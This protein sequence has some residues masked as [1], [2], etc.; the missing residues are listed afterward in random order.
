MLNIPRAGAGA[1]IGSWLA[2]VAGS[3]GDLFLPS[4]TIDTEDLINYGEI[5]SKYFAGQ[6]DDISVLYPYS[7]T[8]GTPREVFPNT[9]FVEADSR[10]VRALRRAGFD[11]DLIDNPLH[12]N[13]T[14]R[15]HLVLAHHSPVDL[16]TLSLALPPIQGGYL[17]GSNSYSASDIL[18][19]RNSSFTRVDY[20]VRRDGREYQLFR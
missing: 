1:R 11:V 2:D 18:A 20:F 9:K 16:L 7:G 15:P 6:I 10:K 13:G 3:A 12:Y 19:Q 8:D 17:L 5:A 14:Q 4:V